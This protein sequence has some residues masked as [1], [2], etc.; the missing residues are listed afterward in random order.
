MPCSRAGAGCSILELGDAIACATPIGLFLGRLANF[1]N[2]E[3]W[4][5]ISDVPWAM[6]FPGA[7]PAPRH[8]SQLYE[9][10]SRALVL[11]AGHDLA[12]AQAARSPARRA[13]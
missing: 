13:A 7:G 9:A 1:I 6:V 5:R 3:L 4:G 11:F 12:R 10:R 8:P 2:G